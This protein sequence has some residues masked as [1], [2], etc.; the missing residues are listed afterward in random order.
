MTELSELIHERGLKSLRQWLINAGTLETAEALT[1]I[2]PEYRALAFRLIPKDRAMD[3][4]EMLDT[5]YQQEILSTLRDRNV[6]DILEKMEPDDRARLLDEMPPVI[7]KQLLEGLSFR[8][9][10][11]TSIL[12]GYPENSAGR[13]MSPEFVGLQKNMTVQDAI[14]KVRKSGRGV[15]AIYSLPVIDEKEHLVGIIDLGDLVLADPGDLV[16]NLAEVTYSVKANQNQEVASRLLLETGL[17]ALPVLD[18]VKIV[19][20]EC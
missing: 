11:L 3:V 9:R 10:R 5:S 1:R 17:I 16:G 19:L 20:W 6:R 14:T 18:T 12:L 8:E 7:A 13:I 2:D 15:E 4:F